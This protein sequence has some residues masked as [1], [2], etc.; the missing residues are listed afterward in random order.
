MDNYSLNGAERGYARRTRIELC[1]LRQ[2]ASID[3]PSYRYA[4]YYDVDLSPEDFQTLDGLK[5]AL[6]DKTKAGFLKSQFFRVRIKYCNEDSNTSTTPFLSS[7]EEVRSAYQ[8]AQNLGIDWS[9]FVVRYTKAQSAQLQSKIP[10]EEYKHLQRLLGSKRKY[11]RH[12]KVLHDTSNYSMIK[13][14]NKEG[15]IHTSDYIDT[16]KSPELSSISSTAS[17]QAHH[18][19]NGPFGAEEFPV[20]ST[21]SSLGL[22]G[23]Y[24]NSHQPAFK[25]NSYA[26]CEP[27]ELF[28]YVDALVASTVDGNVSNSVL[29]PTHLLCDDDGCTQNTF[30]M[31][32]DARRSRDN[33][34]EFPPQDQYQIIEKIKQESPF[35][36]LFSIK[37]LERWANEIQSRAHTSYVFPPTYFPIPDVY[38][39]RGFKNVAV[40]N[41]ILDIA[42]LYSVYLSQRYPTPRGYHADDYRIDD[43]M[44]YLDADED[45][46][47]DEDVDIDGG[48]D[49]DADPNPDVD[50]EEEEEEEEEDG[51]KHLDDTN[52]G[53][54][55]PAYASL[56]S[57]LG[58]SKSNDFTK[59]RHPSYEHHD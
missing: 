5:I 24:N 42:T 17:L 8:M 53:H 54:G 37:G 10:Q 3:R 47:G 32:I 19:H 27:H 18:S 21:G 58:L 56:D 28:S 57:G 25:S 46:D 1:S 12:M 45:G 9:L 50:D 49:G 6:Q 15:I 23:S 7:S 2:D 13:V 29:I 34:A 16:L 30:L 14:S 52:Y 36:K 43:V 22:S 44:M 20:Q 35:S 4:T 31:H 48:V 55:I 11:E 59:R 38:E 26:I 39:T 51:S 33:G 40:E 41:R